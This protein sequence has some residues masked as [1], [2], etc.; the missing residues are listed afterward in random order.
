VYNAPIMRIRLL[1]AI[2]A[3]LL[4]ATA[5]SAH[6][7]AWR[8]PP[9]NSGTPLTPLSPIPVP[10]LPPGS[11]TPVPGPIG[12]LDTPRP[13]GPTIPG[14]TNPGIPRGNAPTSGP[15]SDSWV[16]WWTLN[17]E[18]LLDLT[19]LLRQRVREQTI[20]STPHFLGRPGGRNREHS[21]SIEAREKIL[22]ALLEAA[23]DGN[24]DVAT[25]AIVA[26]GK[27]GDLRAIALL[28]QL[29]DDP[30]ADDTVRESSVLALGMI[31]GE[32]PDRRVFL[33]S[34]A[35]DE[36]RRLRTR[37]FA[38]LA[39]GFL[40]DAAALPDLA[41]LWR[42]KSRN[43]EVPAAALIGLGLMRDEI[44]VPDLSVA[45]SGSANR[46]EKE[47][48]LRA[49]AGTAL[50]MIGSRAGLPAAC[51]ALRDRD[52]QVRRQA[53]LTIGAIAKPGDE[54]ERKA[55]AFL[56]LADRDA[57][58]RAF[59]AIALG[60]IGNLD[61]GN[62]LAF[63]YRKGDSTLAPHA[64][65]ALALLV[66]QVRSAE[67]TER[68]LP[69]LL[70]EFRQR[71]NASLRGAL[72]IALGIIGD[73]QAV[74]ALIDLASSGAEPN[75]RGHAAVALGLIGDD[76]ARPVLRSALSETG[77]PDVQ[78]EVALALALL[79]DRTAADALLEVVKKGTTE[80]ARGGAAAALGRLATEAQALTLTEVLA[81]RQTSDTT[82]AF[83][84]VALG[85]VLERTSEPLLTRIG[86]ALN[87]RMVLPSIAEVLSFL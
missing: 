33:A 79:G 82:R 6:G 55:L 2:L 77:N 67:A 30:K 80:Y 24:R 71:A 1:F 86:V 13:G 41:R 56:L 65:I 76:R 20:S 12:G 49:H 40:G 21:T 19:G 28:R 51:A 85:L 10:T 4:L 47:D 66:R 17:R 8:G 29:A 37:C 45:L 61:D 48:L 68:V 52:P 44:V 73:R 57:M 75:L 27:A 35:A 36:G 38:L 15:G 26:L 53:A 25:G 59:A 7:G 87:H 54:A 78:K 74:P 34:V 46:R 23:K 5:A 58:V 31:G 22:L 63:A 42:T 11:S 70:K 50:A 9:P 72:A 16:W 84:A 81:D 39:L 60:Q 14:D 18:P 83:V 3:I 69:F 64:A 62:T 32:D 43:T